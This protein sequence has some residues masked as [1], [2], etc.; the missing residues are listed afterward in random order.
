[1]DFLLKSKKNHT[2][3]KGTAMATESLPVKKSHSVLDQLQKVQDR[4]MQRAYEIFDGNGQIFGRD[5]DNWLQAETEL[6]WK[7]AIELSEKDNEFLVK[8]AVPGVD[9]KDLNVE[10]TPEELLVKGES[11]HEQEEKKGK[12]HTT[13]IRSGSIFRTIRFPKKVNPD[14]VK[15]EFK[16]GMLTLTAQVAEEQQAKKVNIEA[17]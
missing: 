10:V 5:L 1:M 9:A 3:R 17:A 11:R 12:I 4:I 6:L 15:A 2:N 7:P 14:K 16:N 8:V 13:E